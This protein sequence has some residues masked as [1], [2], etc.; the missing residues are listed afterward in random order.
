MPKDRTEEVE[1]PRLAREVPDVK[2]LQVG[3]RR[4]EWEVD[5]SLNEKNRMI[6]KNEVSPIIGLNFLAT[7]CQNQ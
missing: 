1:G 2:L 3:Q 5:E 6:L 4:L 7:L